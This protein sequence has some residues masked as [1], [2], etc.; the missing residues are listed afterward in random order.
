MSEKRRDKKMWWFRMVENFFELE[1][2]KWL[3][4]QENGKIYCLFYLQLCC[5]ATENE[6]LLYRKI[7]E[8]A[9]PYN[10][11]NLAEIT[12]NSIDTVMIALKVLEKIGLIE[13]KPG[14][15][16]FLKRLAKCIGCTSQKADDMREARRLKK[17]Q[18]QLTTSPVLI[19][20]TN[21]APCVAPDVAH[22]IDIRDYS[23][24]HVFSADIPQKEEIIIPYESIKDLFN[25]ICISYQKIISIE[26]DRKKTVANRYKKYPDIKIFEK[27]FYNVENS[28]YLKNIRK[29]NWRVDFDWIVKI[30][31][32][33]KIY[34][35]KYNNIEGVENDRDVSEIWL[36]GFTNA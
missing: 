29:N 23:I 27:V 31:N 18:K 36:N 34:E 2:I 6:G 8:Y 17:L 12:N 35:G 7:G 14:G 19:G 4:E 11:K 3:C 20:A 15:V 26:G 22:S 32:F 28:D 1:E 33:V 5:K 10:V 16:I 9:I 21:V 13:V 24:N 25:S 30:S